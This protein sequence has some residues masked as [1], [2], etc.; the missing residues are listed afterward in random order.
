ME[1]IFHAGSTLLEGPVWD[2]N[3]KVIYCVSIEQNLIYQILRIHFMRCFI[4]IVL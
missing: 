1:L 2:N 4:R 3:N